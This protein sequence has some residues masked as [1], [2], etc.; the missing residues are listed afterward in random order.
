MVKDAIQTK[1]RN[2]V[3]SYWSLGSLI[4]VDVVFEVGDTARSLAFFYI[5]FL[6]TRACPPQRSY[7][8]A[9]SVHSA[10]GKLHKYHALVQLSLIVPS[11]YT[12]H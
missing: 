6:V 11:P 9:V 10:E 12:A 8:R 7:S 5:P 4:D 1:Y 2:R 3:C